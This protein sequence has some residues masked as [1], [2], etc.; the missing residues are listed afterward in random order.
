MM[1]RA[2]SK[3]L[4]VNSPIPPLR[5]G[6]K[7]GL[8]NEK[9]IALVMVLVLSLIALV[10]VST[11]IYL[12]IQGTKFSGF[13][14]RFETAR[15]AG[16]GGV[17]IAGSLIANRGSLVIPNESGG[18]YINLPNACDCGD[19]ENFDD[20][21]DSTGIR[22]CLCD[23]LCNPPYNSDGVYKWTVAGCDTSL[24][25]TENPDMP[26]FNLA[27]VGSTK[28]RIFAKI[29]DTT[30]GNSD[31]SGESLGGTGVSSSTSSIISAPPLPYLYRIEINSED[32]ANAIERSRL[33][34]LYAY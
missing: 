31:L 21:T 12:V 5:K 19:P 9:G 15:E 3:E 23:K 17:E 28:Y 27:G 30:R 26:P 25:P 22:T 8:F 1:Q 10:I 13:H 33:S 6:G 29:V 2:K 20:N 24:V 18:Y 16:I 32:A 34:V 14:K 4:R 11:L 7:G